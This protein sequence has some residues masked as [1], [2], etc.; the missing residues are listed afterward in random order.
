MLGEVKSKE[1]TSPT[2]FPQRRWY[3]I[4]S[5]RPVVGMTRDETRLFFLSSLTDTTALSTG[6]HLLFISYSLPKYMTSSEGVG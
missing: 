3:M 2:Q 4:V 1:A 5:W 6:L